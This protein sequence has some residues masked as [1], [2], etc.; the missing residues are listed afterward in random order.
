MDN[1]VKFNTKQYPVQEINRKYIF[2][3]SSPSIQSEAK[4][5]KIQTK[6]VDITKLSN[7]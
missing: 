6:P 3:H 1:R 7:A 4:D 5:G 2:D